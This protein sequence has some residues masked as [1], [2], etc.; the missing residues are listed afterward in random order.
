MIKLWG[1]LPYISI[2]DFLIS[3]EGEK[4]AKEKW[5]LKLVSTV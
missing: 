2:I 3:L 5:N 4:N 1:E